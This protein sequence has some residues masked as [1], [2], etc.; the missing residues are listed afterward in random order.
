MIKIQAVPRHGAKRNGRVCSPSAADAAAKV[1]HAARVPRAGTRWPDFSRTGRTV[2][3]W[4]GRP[5]A[6]TAVPLPDPGPLRSALTLRRVSQR[7]K[8]G[9]SL[10]Q[11]N[12]GD[13]SPPAERAAA[14]RRHSPLRDAAPLSADAPTP[15]APLRDCA[16]RDELRRVRPSLGG[17]TAA[18]RDFAR[19]R[20][21]RRH[22]RP[23]GPEPDPGSRAR[24]RRADRAKTREDWSFLKAVLWGRGGSGRGR[25]TGRPAE[26]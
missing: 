21:S 2:R 8:R 22:R 11:A 1:C 17:P 24:R 12:L 14:R 13:A 6:V 20:P 26:G 25:R 23:G 3:T 19:F 16:P 9:G 10:R 5:R 18:S 4:A 15:P 7:G